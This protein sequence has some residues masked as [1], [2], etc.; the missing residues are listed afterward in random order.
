[1]VTLQIA[2]VREFMAQLLLTDR[3]DDWGFEGADIL[4][5][6][7]YSIAGEVNP[8]YFPEGSAPEK[9]LYREVRDTL[10]SIVKSGH[11]PTQMKIILSAPKSVT[12]DHENAVAES[13]LITIHF[14][15]GA[16]KLIGGIAMR[17]FSMDRSDVLYWD[18]KF[19]QIIR[20]C[21]IETE[22]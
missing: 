1:M 14:Q 12:A 5:L 13:Y 17:T 16:C 18:E 11:T 20:Q 2:N 19:V 22:S 7:K 15:N 3:F 8:K 6:T 10:T 21:G 4:A 9:I